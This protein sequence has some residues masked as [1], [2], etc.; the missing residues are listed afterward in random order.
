MGTETKCPLCGMEAVETQQGIIPAYRFKCNTCGIFDISKSLLFYMTDDKQTQIMEIYYK[1]KMSDVIFRASC[2]AAERKLKSEDG[3]T[4]IAKDEIKGTSIHILDF[5]KDFPEDP[6]EKF[7]RALLNL[8][9]MTKTLPFS[10]TNID[11]DQSSILFLSEK[12][13]LPV[14][15]NF[16]EES[17]L[18]KIITD[19]STNDGYDYDIAIT[20][21]GW[22]RIAELKKHYEVNSNKAFIAMWF[23]KSTEAF[24]EEVRVGVNAA[25]YEMTVVDEIPH[26]DFIMDKV[27]N[28]ISESKF[29]IADFTCEP[30]KDAQKGVRGGVYYE[31]GFAGGQDKEV[32]MTCRNDDDSKKRRHFDI[33]QKNTIFWT[34][35]DGKIV[36]SDKGYPLADFLKERIIRT[37]SKGSNYPKK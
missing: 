25:G 27:L 28:S 1:C 33:E 10:T 13:K 8:G 19:S 29:I 35:K 11:E 22:E 34:E 2:I 7:N 5:I 16:L 23:D 12:E 21:H 3:Y 31:A 37:V 30:E 18:I 4:L 17:Q 15:I 36:T 6:I 9:R 24:R 20:P 26:N 14:M 32:I